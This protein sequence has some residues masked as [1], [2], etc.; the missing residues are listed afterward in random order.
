MYI[1]HVFSTDNFCP[2]LVTLTANS[3]CCKCHQ[4]ISCAR[5]VVYPQGRVCPLPADRVVRIA[6][7]NVFARCFP[8]GIVHNININQDLITSQVF[9]RILF[10]LLYFYYSTNTQ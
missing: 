4:G 6:E 7:I 2:A 9:I 10:I 8:E 5:P 1:L 3:S